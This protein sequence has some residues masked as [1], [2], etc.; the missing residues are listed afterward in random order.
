MYACIFIPDFP[1]GA[2]ERTR[3]ELRHGALAV[4]EG[5]PPLSYVVAVNTHARQLGISAGMTKLQA[6]T[7]LAAAA[8]TVAGR[9][10][11]R[12]KASER[13]A[14]AAL[15]D[16]AHA[17][18]PKV[19]DTAGDTVLIDVRGLER[20]F[21]T[22]SQVAREIARRV[23]QQGLEA[24]IAVAATPDTAEHAA[25]G[26]AGTTVLAAGE[27]AQRL[28]PLPLE[29]LFAA[30][31]AAVAR[32]TATASRTKDERRKTLDRLAR[33]QETLDRW[34]IRNFRA[35]ASLPPVS[36]SE[37]LGR[38]GV[39]LQQ[40]AS[41][42]ICRELALS[43]P[44]LTFEEAI[45]LENAAEGIEP[46]LFLLGHMLEQVCTR[47]HTRA[48]CTN[49]LRLRFALEQRTGDNDALT[50]EELEALGHGA[51][52]ERKLT[53]PVPMND[54]R[55]FLKLL[56]LQL[57]SQPLG[58]AVTKI[59]LMAEAA[60]PRIGQAGLFMPLAP[61]AE[62]LE[63]TLARMHKLLSAMP[64]GSDELRAGC[65]ELV[66]SH[67]PGA[68]RMKRFVTPE[69]A[70]EGKT[71]EQPAEAPALALRRMRPAAE[72]MVDVRDGRPARV[73]AE[74]LGLHAPSHENVIWAAGPWRTSGRWWNRGEEQS[75]DEAAAG[76]GWGAGRGVWAR[77]EWDV[78]IGVTAQ[79]PRREMFDGQ[80]LHRTGGR[81]SRATHIALFRIS[82]DVTTGK[83]QLEGSYD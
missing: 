18:S 2:L 19:E 49:E 10:V 72:A 4:V 63:L 78:A 33:M 64:A 54:A 60:R 66:D 14:H 81:R 45:E 6:E 51:V 36:L 71:G 59:R 58:A 42:G 38:H 44:P 35:L 1:A 23:S 75:L 22:A 12:S 30:E 8:P 48:L 50:R 16:A 20:L 57:S 25:R 67:E 74:C 80:A 17:I 69:G 24:N 65:A 70:A 29:V 46:L 79:Q 15:L 61:E 7:L 40:L 3:P 55:L 27:E 68:F 32:G 47:L 53:L 26:F 39:R 34:G 82:H 37:R 56:H 28:A 21:G 41:G 77:D 9:V 83:W 13:G 31:A 5:T 62:K 73:W 52:V 43:E 11:E 76:A